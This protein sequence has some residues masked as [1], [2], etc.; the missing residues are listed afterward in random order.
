MKQGRKIL[1]RL[2]TRRAS[3]RQA[4]AAPAN[5]SRGN[6]RLTEEN[7]HIPGSMRSKGK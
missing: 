1:R 6:S 5:Q 2:E 4:I 3:A 7:Y